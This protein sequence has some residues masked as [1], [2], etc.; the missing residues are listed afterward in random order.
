LERWTG[1]G[2]GDCEPSIRRADTAEAA[3]E[4]EGPWKGI[5]KSTEESDCESSLGVASRAAAAEAALERRT[6]SGKGDCEPS[7]RR[8][9]TAE[10]AVEQEGP[11]KGIDKSTEESDCESSFEVLKR[12]AAAAAALEGPAGSGDGEGEGSIMRAG[13]AR[14]AVEPE[15]GWQEIET[16]TED[17]DC[18][19]SSD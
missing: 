14:A 15:G 2:K 6:G 7:I 10:A 18:E 13:T 12:A 17:S 9:D 3:V 5:D 16:C 4:Q 19:A 1:S 8:A 11:W